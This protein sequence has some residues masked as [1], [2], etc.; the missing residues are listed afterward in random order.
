MKKLIFF[1]ACVAASAVCHQAQAQAQQVGV[2]TNLL[3]DVTATFNLGAEIRLGGRTSLDVPVSWNPFTFSENRKWKHILVQ[4]EFRLWTKETFAGHFFGLHGHYAFYNAGNLPKPFS[5]YM[6]DHRFQGRLAGAGVSYG[7]RWNFGRDKAA[8]RWGM[9]ATVGV[10]YAYLDYDRYD[11]GK[12]GEKLASNTKHYFGP[13]K[14]GLSL[15]Y[16]IGKRK[17]TAP[18]PVPVP[19]SIPLV[20]TKEEP[21]AV[22]LP[23]APRFAVSY[24]VPEAEAVKVRSEAGKA[25]YLDFAAG[26]ADIVPDFKGNAAELEKIYAMIRGVRENPDA[27]ITGIT[28]TGYA[29]PDGLYSTNLSLSERRALSLKNQIKMI[30]GYPDGFFTVIGKGEDWNTLDSLVAQSTMTNKYAVLEIIRGT[31]VFDGREKKLMTLAGGVPY[32]QMK[33]ELFPQLRRTEYQLH[34][35][36]LPFMVEKG[37]EVFKTR[38]ASLSLNEMFL[39]ANTYEAGSDRFNKVFETAARMYPQDDA[40]NLNAAAS[41]LSR[42]DAVQAENFLSKVKS[43]SAAYHNNRGVLYGLRG[44]WDKAA[45]SFGKARAAGNAEAAANAGEIERKL[46]NIEALRRS[47]KR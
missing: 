17:S 47:E 44:E 30:T 37:K 8:S 13:T 27:E 24:A 43:K 23:Y 5:P 35:T 9:E 38:P 6:R 26:K 16:S 21:E 45:E 39:I 33:A 28:I 10:G 12:C 7:Y 40:A 14:V 4:P 1:C 31:D 46:E 22:V 20:V 3:Y 42:G 19:E 25:A 32:R 41:A 36:I 15:I 11:C 2:K 29:S 34:Y 18:A